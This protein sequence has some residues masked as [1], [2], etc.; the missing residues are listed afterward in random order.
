VSSGGTPP[1]QPATTL[2]GPAQAAPSATGATPN[3]ADAGSTTGHV[4][5]GVVARVFDRVAE[6]L[7]THL[8]EAA[9]VRYASRQE[10]EAARDKLL[11]EAALSHFPGLTDVLSEAGVKSSELEAFVGQHP[12][13]VK[14]QSQRVAERIAE[15]AGELD[16]AI[17]AQFPPK[18]TVGH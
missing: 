5:A 13:V 8:R 12:E 14:R 11:S 6:L 4:D 17:D 18:T 3:E 2:A 10:A 16:A 15:A 7:A 9:H 1:A